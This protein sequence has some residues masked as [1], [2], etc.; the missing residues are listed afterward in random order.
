MLYTSCCKF[1]PI[2]ITNLRFNKIGNY[3]IYE[4]TKNNNKIKDQNMLEPNAI[5]RRS[6]EPN[7]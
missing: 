3:Y 1:P 5:F 6:P 7:L 2:S 4:E